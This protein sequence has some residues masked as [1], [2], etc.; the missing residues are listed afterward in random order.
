MRLRMRIALLSL[1][2]AASTLPARGASYPPK[3]PDGQA[4][5]TDQVGGVSVDFMYYPGQRYAGKPWSNWGDGLA[6]DGKYYSS[7]GDHRFNAFVYEYDSAHKRLRMIINIKELLGL[8]ENAYTPGKVHGRLDVGNDGNIYFSTH[9]GSKNYTTEEYH[10]Q[11]DWIF[12]YDPKTAKAGMASRA[13]PPPGVLRSKRHDYESGLP[14]RQIRPAAF[15]SAGPDVTCRMPVMRTA[16]Q[17]SN[18][19]R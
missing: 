8:P 4:V 12:R 6:V 5:V 1:V 17:P 10:Y 18:R 2:W 14:H 9:R 19:A 7:I 11:G 13:G 3:L 16:D 15:P